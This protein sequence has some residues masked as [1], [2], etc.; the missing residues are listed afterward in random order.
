MATKVSFIII[1]QDQYSRVANRIKNATKGMQRKFTDLNKTTTRL[2][3]KMRAFRMQLS[4]VDRK[5]KEMQRGLFHRFSKGMRNV[6][7]GMTVG[8]TLPI[9]LMFKSFKDA[10]RDAEET[11]SKFATVFRSISNESEMVADNFAKNFG[12][13]GT[14]SRKLLGDTADL[15]SGFGFTQES[16]LDLSKQVN[17]LAVDLASFTNIEGGAAQASAALTKA[18]LGERESIKTL[19]IAILEA[20]VKARVAKLGKEG[21]T[22]ATMRQAKAFATL[23]LATEQSKNAIGDFARTSASLANQ[24]RITAARIQDMKE[25]M[26]KILLPVALKLTKAIA[27]MAEWFTNLSPRMQKIIL[28]TAGVVAVVGPL[29]LVLGAVLTMLP[30]MAAGWSMMAVAVNA[31]LW[32]ILAIGA[33][34]YAGWK[35]GK[36]LSDWLQT[37][38]GYIAVVDAVFWALTNPLEAV[39]CLWEKLTGWVS[40][41]ITEFLEIP[42]VTE[43]IAVAMDLLLLPITAVTEGFKVLW[44]FGGKVG[45]VI[46]DLAGGALDSLLSLFGIE[47]FEGEL[48]TSAFSRSDVN[49]NM[50]APPG[51]VKEVQTR[52]TGSNPGLNIGVNMQESLS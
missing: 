44:D 28:I 30:L 36:F 17:E 50:N 13:A 7:A 5:M 46:S 34:F 41:L 39:T 9:A 3:A 12:L 22:F 20:D 1:A 18:L 21:M 27:R 24:E 14:E 2:S 47:N 4:K 35:I 52:T 49:V 10:A 33:A 6:G 19:G 45:Q 43:G 42:G 29:L 26:G 40:G 15:L 23:Q 31:A 16:S 25:A 11:R 38:P 37:L 8:V 32:P 48:N 51:V